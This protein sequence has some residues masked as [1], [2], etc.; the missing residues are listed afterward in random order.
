MKPINLRDAI[1]Q[2]PFQPFVLEMDNGRS[3]RVPH[4]D[5]IFL[6]PAGSTA[7]VVERASEGEH[8]HIVDVDHVSM[9]RFDKKAA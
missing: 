4:R 8:T 6:T 1:E 9:I 2:V 7:V 5:F 3:L